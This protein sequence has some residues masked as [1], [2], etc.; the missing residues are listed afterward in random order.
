M[1]RKIV[2]IVLII[3]GLVVEIIAQERIFTRQ[4]TLRGTI[5][6]ERAW[7]DL[8]YYHLSV[9]VDPADSSFTGSN[10]IQYWVIDP[11]QLIQI[12][13]QPPMEITRIS[14]KWGRSEI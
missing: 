5:T 6:L 3:F 13:L 7:W 11:K 12:D 2:T 14:Q 1:I 4:D 8:T 10:L 9:N